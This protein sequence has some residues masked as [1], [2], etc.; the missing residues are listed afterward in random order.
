MDHPKQD[1]YSHL[2][3]IQ[4]IAFHHMPE[5]HPMAGLQVLANK[6]Y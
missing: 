6:E 4:S 3:I 1:V 2:P 5:H